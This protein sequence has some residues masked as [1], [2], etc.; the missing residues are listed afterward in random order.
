MDYGGV[1]DM[2][3]PTAPAAASARGA[4]TFADAHAEQLRIRKLCDRQRQEA[5]QMRD[6]ART[7]VEET[8]RGLGLPLAGDLAQRS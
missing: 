3:I 8:R 4:P 2:D 5:R 7:M 1:I 6:Q